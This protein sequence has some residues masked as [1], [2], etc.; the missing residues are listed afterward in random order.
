M[1][2]GAQPAALN[3]TH[4]APSMNNPI[5]HTSVDPSDVISLDDGDFGKY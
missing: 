1:S 5:A 2:G 3:P 4:N